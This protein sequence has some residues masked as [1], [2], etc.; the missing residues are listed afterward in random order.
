MTEAE[1]E[2][3][4]F[5]VGQREWNALEE[6]RLLKIECDQLQIDMDNLTTKWKDIDLLAQKNNNNVQP[7]SG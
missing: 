7:E 6:V 1:K 3:F 5:E 4:L 2:N